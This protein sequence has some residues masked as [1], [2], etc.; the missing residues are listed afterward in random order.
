MTPSQSLS[1]TGSYT[2]NP[3]DNKGNIKQEEQAE[4]KLQARMSALTLQGSMGVRRDLLSS[5]NVTLADVAL[6]YR[7]S[8]WMELLTGYRLNRQQAT[9]E[10]TTH[11]YRLGYR[12][13][14]SDLFNIS[15]EGNLT[16]YQRDRIFQPNQTEYEARLK[17]GVKF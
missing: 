12:Y 1:L 16:T 4:L 11:T 14:L 10:L 17:L 6:I 7:F 3:E 2:R 9:S 15:L 5:T 8:P 13:A